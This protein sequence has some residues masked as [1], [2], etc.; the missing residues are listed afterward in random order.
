PGPRTRLQRRGVG[1]GGGGPAGGRLADAGVAPARLTRT[2]ADGGGV[3]LRGGDV[4]ARAD[5][6]VPLW[7]DPVCLP[8]EAGCVLRPAE[9][10]VGRSLRGTAAPGPHAGPGEPR[11]PWPDPL[12]PEPHA[13]PTRL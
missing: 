12:A 13:Q 8:D 9:A 10:E 7:R 11:V 4:D 3:A 6:R 1:R 5:L 2:R